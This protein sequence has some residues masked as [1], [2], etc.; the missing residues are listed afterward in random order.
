MRTNASGF[1][2]RLRKHASVHTD[3]LECRQVDQLF[4][5][6]ITSTGVTNPSRYSAADIAVREIFDELAGV[7]SGRS[8]S[9]DGDEGED[10]FQKQ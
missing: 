2:A 9:D 10:R 8:T 1:A 7:E 4:A 5:A 3:M 6:M